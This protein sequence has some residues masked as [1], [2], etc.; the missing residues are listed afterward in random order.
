MTRRQALRQTSR[1]TDSIST[2]APLPYPLI[3]VKVIGLEKVHRSDM[4]SLKT[5]CEHIDC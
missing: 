5:F 1:K 3:N 4:K 2:P